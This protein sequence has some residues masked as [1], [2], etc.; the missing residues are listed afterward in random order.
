MLRQLAAALLLLAAAAAR[1]DGLDRDALLTEAPATPHSGTVRVTAGAQS[2]STDSA[3]TTSITGDL[4]WAP[5][6]NFA[7]DVGTYWQNSQNGP[8]VRLRVQ[9]L[10]QASAG[11]DLGVGVRFKKVS[12]FTH[13]LD[14]SPNGELEFLLA[15]GHRFGRFELMVNGVVGTETGGPGKDIEGKLFAGYH[16]TETVRAGLDG[17]LQAEF[18]D[19]KGVKTPQSADMDLTVGPALSVL[20]MK[21]F[22]VQALIGLAKPKGTTAA[23]GAGLLLAS[24]DF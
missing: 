11:I 10:S 21:R 9:I 6:Q 20:L 8:T 4:L 12:F 1:A 16:F 14:G 5:V 2:Q 17:R 15:G 7:A 19:E 13:P 23:T 3:N 18:V 24:A 22:Q